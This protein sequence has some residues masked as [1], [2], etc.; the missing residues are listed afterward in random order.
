MGRE[1][2]N[3]SWFFIR[4]TLSVHSGFYSGELRTDS[5]STS[6]FVLIQIGYLKLS[7]LKNTVP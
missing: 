4:I 1:K 2:L 6:T 3:S 5:P 7:S